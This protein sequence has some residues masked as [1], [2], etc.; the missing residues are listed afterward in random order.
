MRLYILLIFLFLN[1]NLQSQSELKYDSKSNNLPDWV[2]LMYSQNI[3]EGKE[4]NC[5]RELLQKK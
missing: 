1:F 4:I 3:D 2:K 5:L